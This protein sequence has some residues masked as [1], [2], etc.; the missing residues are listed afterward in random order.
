[1]LAVT[2]PNNIE[3]IKLAS[4]LLMIIQINYMETFILRETI[5]NSSKFQHRN[6]YMGASIIRKLKV[7]YFGPCFSV[8]VIY[9]GGVYIRENL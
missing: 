6:V 9:A 8:P 1:M 2:K 7:Y 5:R 4:H 3:T